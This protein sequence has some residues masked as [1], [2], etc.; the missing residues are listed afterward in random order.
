MHLFEAET[1]AL[2]QT[3]PPSRRSKPQGSSKFKGSTF[4]DHTPLPIFR[5]TS[6]SV[7]CA[8]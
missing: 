3:E 6:C 2:T 4:N 7:A 5:I 1:D 8:G